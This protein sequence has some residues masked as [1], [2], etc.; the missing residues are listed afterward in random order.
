MA[1]AGGRWGGLCCRS[2]L[3]VHCCEL[4]LRLGSCSF[5]AFQLGWCCRFPDGEDWGLKGCTREAS[6]PEEGAEG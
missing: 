2:A 3:T 1:V 4:L 6:E 5:P